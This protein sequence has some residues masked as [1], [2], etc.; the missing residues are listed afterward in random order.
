VQSADLGKGT[1]AVLSLEQVHEDAR[2]ME[3]PSVGDS[4]LVLYIHRLVSIVGII[5]IVVVV[6]A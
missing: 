6:A 4:I 3:E 5:N 1:F 2:T